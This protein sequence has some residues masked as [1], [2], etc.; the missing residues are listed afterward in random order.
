MEEQIEVD[1]KLHFLKG[2]TP[3]IYRLLVEEGLTTIRRIAISTV[4]DIAEIEDISDLRGI[5]SYQRNRKELK[6]STPHALTSSG[7]AGSLVDDD[8]I[9]IDGQA[10]LL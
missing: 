5:R 9:P 3:K 6:K 8:I 4:E 10:E 2:M 1:N 7:N